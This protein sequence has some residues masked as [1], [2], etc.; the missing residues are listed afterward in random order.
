MGTVNVTFGKA[1]GGGAPVY[2]TKPRS[3]ENVTTSTSSAQSTNTAEPGDFVSI[4]ALDANVYVS[5][6][7]NPTAV[8]GSGYCVLSGQTK[9]FGPCAMGDKVALIESA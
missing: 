6:G 4:T 1:M 2:A 5:I 9:D 3:A 7:T 8:A